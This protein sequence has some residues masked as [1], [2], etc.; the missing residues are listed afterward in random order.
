MNPYLSRFSEKTMV[1]TLTSSL[2]MAVDFLLT[3]PSRP[4][5]P[6]SSYNFPP[7]DGSLTVPEMFDWHYQNNADHRSIVY[8]NNDGQK[9][10]LSFT[11]VV[12][13]V[14]RAARYVAKV[15]GI[16]LETDEKRP[17]VAIIAATGETTLAFFIRSFTRISTY[18]TWPIH[19]H[20][21]FYYDHS[22]KSVIISIFRGF[23]LA[24]FP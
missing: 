17:L 21:H 6:E 2:Q 1:S 15:S 8:A 19:R 12:P 9:T 23:L 14:H 18:I 3:P 11:D 22:W 24:D 7:L 5:N 20:H 16:D 4:I 13:A 10:W